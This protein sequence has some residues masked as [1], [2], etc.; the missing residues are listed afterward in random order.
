M[1]VTST[2]WCIGSAKFVKEVSPLMDRHA[3]IRWVSEPASVAR[4]FAA[5]ACDAAIIEHSTDPAVRDC[6]ELIK[7][8]APRAQRVV[9]FDNCELRIIRTY[10][11]GQ[12]ATE[13]VY[14]PLDPVALLKAC[15]VTPATDRRSPSLLRSDRA[16]PS[17]T[18][19]QAAS[20]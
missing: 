19:H 5:S 11:E 15:G 7:T 14:R 6:L 17:N 18:A 8:R 10:L 12:L 20:E 4:L 9:V 1:Q 16:V 2:V 13:L 3:R